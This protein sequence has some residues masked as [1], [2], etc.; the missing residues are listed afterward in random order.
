MIEAAVVGTAAFFCVISPLNG[1]KI[2]KSVPDSVLS[3][4]LALEAAM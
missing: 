1:G 3:K 2:I 4:K